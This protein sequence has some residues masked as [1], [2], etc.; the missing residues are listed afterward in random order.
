M[1]SFRRVSR[2]A[3]ASVSALALLVSVQVAMAITAEDVMKKMS[4]E[5]RFSYLTGLIDMLAYQTAAA[6]NSAKASCI[7]NVYYRDGKDVAWKNLYDA[8]DNFSDRQPAIIVALLVKKACE[9]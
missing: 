4:K 7:N 1:A 8:F 3:A 6:G 5:E 2:V 9:K